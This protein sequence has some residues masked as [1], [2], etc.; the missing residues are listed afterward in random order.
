MTTTLLPA[1]HAVATVAAALLLVPCAVLWLELRAARRAAPATPPPAPRPALTVLVPAHNEARGLAATLRSIAPQLRLDDRLLVVADN[2]DDETAAV[3]R[4]EGAAVVER[5]EPAR[6]GKGYALDFGLRHCSA[7]PDAVIVMVDADCEL[8]AGCLDRL[9]ATLQATQRPVQGRYLM[10]APAGAPLRERIAQF[11]WRLKNAARPQ[12]AAALG[13]PCLLAGSGMA[14]RRAQLDTVRLA[15]A[16]IV[17]DMQ[18]GIDLALAGHAPVFE[19]GAL[20][21]SRFAGDARAAAAQRRRWEHGHLATLLREVPRLL[22]A[23]LRRRSRALAGLALEL[24]VPPLAA[25][26]LALLATTLASA[27]LAALGAGVAALLLCGLAAALFAAALVSG[28]QHAGRDLVRAG[29]WPLLACFAL[30]KLPLYLAFL[31]R[32]RHRSWNR[33]RRE[34]E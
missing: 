10:Q 1:L 26:A 14:F 29:E 25:L 28:W 8:E 4:R 5:H 6:R 20:V 12:G 19:P 27:L 2:C 21:T 22:A 11:A 31:G 23:A 13:W 15:S 32:Q 9:A 16:N 33:A 17:E 7:A 3:A 18:L 24:A 34:G 30:R